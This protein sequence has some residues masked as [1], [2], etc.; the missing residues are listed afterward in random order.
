[1]KNVVFLYI[2]AILANVDLNLKLKT[3]GLSQKH[4]GMKKSVC[5]ACSEQGYTA[6]DTN[7]CVSDGVRCD[8]RGG[9]EKFSP[10][11]MARHK[12]CEKTGPKFCL[13]CAKT[14]KGCRK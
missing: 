4:K 13:R 9:V 3:S 1:M 11:S 14:E 2:F 6:A 8:C 10:E 5:A 7:T 12:K